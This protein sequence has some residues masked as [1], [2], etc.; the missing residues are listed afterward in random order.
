MPFYQIGPLSVSMED[1]PESWRSFRTET[2]GGALLRVERTEEPVDL[3]GWE[4]VAE[5][6][7]MNVWRGEDPSS[8]WLFQ[9]SRLH[10]WLRLSQDGMS[11]RYHA[12]GAS[13]ASYALLLQAA[14]ECALIR[15]GVMVLH[16]ACVC[17]EGQ[18]VAFSGPSGSGK[19][20]RAAKW[21]E[22]FS[23][24]WLSGD[25]PAI[26]PASGIA[27]GVP[28]DGKEQMFVNASAPLRAILEVRRS[29]RTELR[30]MTDRQAWAFLSGQL[31]IPMWD[32]PLAAKALSGLRRLMRQVPVYR[33]YSDRNE[34][35]AQMSY[36]LLFRR[37]EQI[38][39]F[40]EEAR[41]KLKPG[42]EIVEIDNDYLALPTGENIAVFAGSVVLNEVSAALLREL[43]K[44]ECSREDLLELLLNEYEVERDVAARD[45][46]MILKT[47]AELGLIEG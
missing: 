39:S 29:S 20:T 23:A 34:D 16:A 21:V 31:L 44:R 25:R 15:Q 32:T 33:L 41:M 22:L 7:M 40:E 19:S 43:S 2:A 46:D 30:R 18:A 47:F 26:D 45:L 36:Q 14:A 24:Q 17:V 28:W 11:A 8:G 4:L 9:D 3:T 1:A 5:H 42:F 37:P 13:E 27:I 12:A 6:E 10:G 35:S 38:K